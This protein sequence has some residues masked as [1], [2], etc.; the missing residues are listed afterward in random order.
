MNCEECHRAWTTDEKGRLWFFEYFNRA[1]FTDEEL[2]LEL[3]TEENQYSNIP[4]FEEIA[5]TIFILVPDL[6]SLTFNQWEDAPHLFEVQ[7]P[8][9]NMPKEV[10]EDINNLLPCTVKVEFSARIK[11]TPTS[12]PDIQMWNF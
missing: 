10:Q 1:H 8:G 6:Q 4:T 7:T 11:G 12:K 2:D 9:F 5:R 3:L